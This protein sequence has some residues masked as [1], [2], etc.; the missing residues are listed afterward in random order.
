MNMEGRE[1]LTGKF[2]IRSSHYGVPVEIR[3]CE[4]ETVMG[5]FCEMV[6]EDEF[7]YKNRGRLY[8]AETP[9]IG[10]SLELD[11]NWIPKRGI[12]S[13]CMRYFPLNDINDIHILKRE[14]KIPLE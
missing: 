13:G 5:Y 2:S 7:V 6:S 3:T 1:D 12:S 10:I 11:H 14:R 8:N 4:A 9:Y